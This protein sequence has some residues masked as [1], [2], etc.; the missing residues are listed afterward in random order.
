MMDTG[1]T[2][3]RPAQTSLSNRSLFMYPN[4][5]FQWFPEVPSSLVFV[6]KQTAEKLRKKER[7]LKPKGG[8]HYRRGGIRS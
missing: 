6:T 7:K 8:L 4:R 1:D 2:I 5:H 3:K